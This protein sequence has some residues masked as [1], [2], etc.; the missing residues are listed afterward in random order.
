[1][2]I[3]V[4]QSSDLTGHDLKEWNK[5]ER[6]C[7]EAMKTKEVGA[8]NKAADLFERAA[9]LRKAVVDRLNDRKDQAELRATLD[10]AAHHARLRGETVDVA[11]TG[12]IDLRDR[13]GLK[14]AFEARHLEGH[15]NLSAQA[16][17]NT[18]QLYR[19]CYERAEGLSTPQGTGTSAGRREG[20]QHSHL[21]AG[22]ILRAMRANQSPKALII[23]DEVCG[24]DNTCAVAA[25]KAKCRRTVAQGILKDALA[26][27]HDNHNGRKDRDDEQ[28]RLPSRVELEAKLE[29]VRRVQRAA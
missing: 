9:K 18:G 14:S 21:D 1:M 13:Q 28:F 23:L 6:L 3:A 5:A 26:I 17:Y 4:S 20:L 22:D 8:K 29:A 19:A 2:T 10:Q 24:K 27:A 15:G 12:R 25:K 16:L 11:K 7:S